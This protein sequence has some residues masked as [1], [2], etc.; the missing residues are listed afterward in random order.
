[1]NS[2]ISLTL[3]TAYAELLERTATADF[4][5]Q[6]GE[7][8]FVAKEV[9]GR[10]YWYFQ[11][12]TKDDRRQLYVGPETPELLDRIANARRQ[13][14]DLK[15]RRSLVSTL[16]R[17][18]FL[19]KP[20]EEVGN[21]I[22]A[23]SAAGIFRLRA[24]LVGTVAFQTYSAMLGTRL[25]NAS[26]RTDDI[27]VAQDRN[28][29]LAIEDQTEPMIEILRRADA[30][31][32]S[33]PTLHGAATFSYRSKKLRVDIL[34]PN[35]GPDSDAP[36][37]LHALGSEA[38]QLRFLDFLIRD[39]EPAVLLHDAGV[40]VTVPAPERYALHK[41]IVAARRK[42]GT[43][44]ADKDL[45]QAGALLTVLVKKRPERL[46]GMWHEA[47]ERGPAWR[48]S[49]LESLLSINVGT[50]D[51]LLRSV[52]ETRAVLPHLDV[53]FEDAPPRYDL[54]RAAVLFRGVSMDTPIM[55]GI[56]REAFDDH[57]G[58]GTADGAAESRY[59][60]L[61]RGY[62]AAIEA[63]ARTKYLEAP[64][65]DPAMTVLTTADVAR[66]KSRKNRKSEHNG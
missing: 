17:S 36:V 46:K 54:P 65:D 8:T 21:T 20:P 6:F 15:A 19:P 23:M 35:A 16:I 31:F 52:G 57:F 2:E 60:R 40:F 5:T 44:K 34:T 45:R 64:I 63:M 42:I 24:V 29:S 7:G 26:M 1:M 11:K 55:F 37:R 51:E 50:R 14:D 66:M 53:R 62:R 61:F 49:M 4:E 13:S 47:V 59:V 43:A 22:A 3:Q 32:H 48:T 27:D 33:V 10:R 28:I 30:D 18:A 38:Q 58:G 9:K 41:L 12:P 25:P 39:P 56:S